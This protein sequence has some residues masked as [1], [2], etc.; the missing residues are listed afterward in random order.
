MTGQV[1]TA[2]SV[3]SVGADGKQP[4]NKKH[5]EIIANQNRHGNLQATEKLQKEQVSGGAVAK[6][7]DKSNRETLDAISMTEL[8][9]T[10]Y[11]LRMPVSDDRRNSQK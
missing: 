1:K 9:E 7:I 6:N 3:S 10:V 8:Y 2:G 11:P 4:L 5:N